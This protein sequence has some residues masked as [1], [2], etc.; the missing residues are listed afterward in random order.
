MK[1]IP[2]TAGLMVMLPAL[3]A[4]QGAATALPTATPPAA[5]SSHEASPTLAATSTPQ[6]TATPERT[7]TPEAI[8]IAFTRYEGNP[9]LVAGPP[10]SWEAAVRYGNVLVKDGVYHLFYTGVNADGDRFAIGYA[11]SPDGFSFTR[12]EGN[13]ILEGDGEGFDAHSVSRPVVVV[14]GE[15]WVMYYTAHPRPGHPLS[16]PAIGR[17]TA[18]D[19]AGPWSRDPEAVMRMGSRTDWDGEPDWFGVSPSSVLITDA[20][21]IMYYTSHHRGEISEPRV[22]GACGMATSPDGIEWTKYDDPATTAQPLA[23]SDPV[24]QPEPGGFDNLHAMDCRVFR[25]AKGWNMVY[26]ALRESGLAHE[27]VFA[28]SADGIHWLK[29]NRGTPFLRARHESLTAQTPDFPDLWPI[30]V[31]SVGSD[32][33]LYYDIGCCPPIGMGVGTLAIGP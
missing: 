10:D 9:V 33:R 1:A 18:S 5:T 32:Y 26:A 19:P 17:V 3:I 8:P 24:L 14:D 12:Y 4:C 16:G 27:I 15:T 29:N 20:G 30:S 22:G 13:P 25:S 21:Y 28:T 23:H 2:L 6:P 31:I 7:A 11:T